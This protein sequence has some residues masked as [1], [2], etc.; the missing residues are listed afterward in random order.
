MT[1][2]KQNEIIEYVQYLCSKEEYK[3]DPNEI[4][5]IFSYGRVRA[6]R[7]EETVYD[8]I[9]IKNKVNNYYFTVKGNI[10]SKAIAYFLLDGYVREREYYIEKQIKEITKINEKPKKRQPFLNLLFKKEK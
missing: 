8:S 3:V 1:E 2:E 6:F 4:K 5:I 9:T 10:D 7:N